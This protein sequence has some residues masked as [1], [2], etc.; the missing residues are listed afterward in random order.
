M[1]KSIQ[2]IRHQSPNNEE[3]DIDHIH[4][5]DE[6]YTIDSNNKQFT[7]YVQNEERTG[8]GSSVHEK[9]MGEIDIE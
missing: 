1:V 5:T 8:W 4:T 7:Q 2:V 9:E 3:G 6:K